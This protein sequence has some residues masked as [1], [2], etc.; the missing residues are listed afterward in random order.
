M[1]QFC[2]TD[3]FAFFLQYSRDFSYSHRKMCDILKSILI[4]RSYLDVSLKH[5]H[6]VFPERGSPNSAIELSLEELEEYS[7]FIEWIDVCKIL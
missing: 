4:Y 2:K 6:T 3:Y 7:G 1:R 5:F